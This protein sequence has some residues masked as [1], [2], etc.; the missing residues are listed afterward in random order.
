[1]IYF[2]ELKT[3]LGPAM[4]RVEDDALTGFWFV[5]QKYYP[6]ETGHWIEMPDHSV[7]T[8]LKIWLERYFAGCNPA[9]NVILAPRGSVFQEKVW[10]ILLQI[11]YGKLSSYGEI[12][13]RLA[14]WAGRVSARAVGGAVGRNPISLLIPCHRVVGV[15][16]D[17]TGYAGGVDK[18]AA[19]LRLEGADPLARNLLWS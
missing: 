14:V 4:A 10:E 18:K 2:S 9:P 12:A 3:P 13:G 6:A 17:L 1:M 8:R 19:L 5:G 16:G 7:F 15:N 11:P